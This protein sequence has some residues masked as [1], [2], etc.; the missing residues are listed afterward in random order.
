MA[1]VRL[2]DPAYYDREGLMHVDPDDLGW[3]TVKFVEPQ[4]CGHTETICIEC[5]DSWQNDYEV[6]L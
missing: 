3:H 4:S 5:I 6:Q 2:R 1:R